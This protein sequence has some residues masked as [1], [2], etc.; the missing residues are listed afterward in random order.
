[1]CVVW[2]IDHYLWVWAKSPVA[3]QMGQMKDLSTGQVTR[4]EEFFNKWLLY[5]DSASP[6]EKQNL[7]TST[8]CIFKIK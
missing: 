6:L 2:F 4:P 7:Q 8:S 5:W 3:L 1:M